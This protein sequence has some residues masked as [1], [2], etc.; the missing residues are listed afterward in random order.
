MTK[1]PSQQFRSCKL[2][3]MLNFSEC[4]IGFY[5][6]WI[7]LHKSVAFFGQLLSNHQKTLLQC[8][9]YSRR[10]INPPEI[11]QIHTE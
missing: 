11:F 5:Q 10:I 1:P 7:L 2:S 4:K 8:L 6:G 3:E 9:T